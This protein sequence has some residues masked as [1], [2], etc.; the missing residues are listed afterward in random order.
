MVSK[1]TETAEAADSMAFFL[2]VSQG[3]R[4]YVAPL[5]YDFDANGLK[6]PNAT[7]KSALGPLVELRFAL[8]GSCLQ[9]VPSGTRSVLYFSRETDP[10]GPSDP[11]EAIAEQALLDGTVPSLQ[12]GVSLAMPLARTVPASG[13]GGYILPTYHA[14]N[15]SGSI[16]KDSA[17]TLDIK[18][19]GLGDVEVKD[20]FTVGDPTLEDGGGCK[21]PCPPPIP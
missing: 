18:L 16:A 1:S 9:S 14:R 6:I 21:Y 8:V 11:L 20:A 15:S 12:Q 5:P 7:L 13:P 2:V 17:F 3:D 10:E 19:S 4:R